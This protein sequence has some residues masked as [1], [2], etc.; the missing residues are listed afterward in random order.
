[1]R[2]I[3]G[4]GNTGYNGWT[5]T[6]ENGLNPLNPKDFEHCLKGE[7]ADAMLAEHVWEHMTLEDGIIVAKKPLI[8]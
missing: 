6:Q 5:A 3:I 8:I 2:L 4:A 7:L 1:M